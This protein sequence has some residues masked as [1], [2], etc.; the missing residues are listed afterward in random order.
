MDKYIMSELKHPNLIRCVNFVENDD[1][2]LFVMDLHVTDLRELI[3]DCEGPIEEKT[4]K[5]IFLKMLKA[6]NHLHKH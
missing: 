2:A 6:V 5:Q 1:F 3:H 4:A